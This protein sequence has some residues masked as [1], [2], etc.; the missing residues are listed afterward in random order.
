MISNLKIKHKLL[1]I[2]IICTLIVLTISGVFWGYSNYVEHNNYLNSRITGEAMLVSSNIEAALL[3][4]DAEASLEIL[5]ALN[6]EKAILRAELINAEQQVLAKLD[7]NRANSPQWFWQ[8]LINYSDIHDIRISKTPVMDDQIV[9]GQL[10]IYYHSMEIQE[11]IWTS[12]ITILAVIAL[13]I[14][15]SVVYINYM[16]QIVTVP[17]KRLSELARKVTRSKNY[18]LRGESIYPDEMGALTQDFNIMLDL[19][20]QSNENLEQLVKDRTQALELNNKELIEQIAQREKAERAKKETDAR[21]QQAFFNAPIGMALVDSSGHVFNRNL[22]FDKLLGYKDHSSVELALLISES[23]RNEVMAELSAL[24]NKDNKTKFEREICCQRS[25]LDIIQTIFSMSAVYSEAGEFIYTVLQIQDITA[26]K[27]LEHKLEHLANH[28]ALTDLPNRRALKTALTELQLSQ[29]HSKTSHALCVLDLDRFKLINDSCGHAAG[30]KLLQQIADLLRD[31]VRGKNLAAR[32]GGDEFALILYDCDSIKAREQTE[33]IRAEIEKIE[34]HWD[35]TTYRLG[36]SI[37]VSVSKSSKLDIS[38]WL[39]QAD[40]ACFEAKDMGRNRVFIVDDDN[41]RLDEQQRD[42]QWIQRI[43]HAISND[44]FVLFEQ[45][46]TP[47]QKPS[48]TQH[49]EI[50]IRL[51][52]SEDGTLIPPNNFLHVAERYGLSSKIDQWA[53]NYLIEKLQNN[54]GLAGRDCHYWIN[55]SGISLG[56]DRF[57]DFLENAV[58]NADI[59]V[60]TLN[61]EITETAA[62]KNLTEVSELMSRLIL[63]GC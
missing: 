59:P 20:E 58:R 62:I 23:N 11:A 24:S 63:L 27:N 18:S 36:V 46:I 51:K 32:L 13:A 53:V 16:Q 38:D 21:F 35:G 40:S 43:N 9:I 3:F 4:D 37:G 7:F 56:D 19:V 12:F 17:I 54:S 26:S 61:F 49:L 22:S 47:L 2:N 8:K 28:D 55:L 30:D 6:A 5:G 31:T 1:A 33:N 41:S 15:I 48:K 25:N 14:F 50:L 60:G 52:N 57:H 45:P 39:K 34:F 10:V 44:E 29:N 42:M